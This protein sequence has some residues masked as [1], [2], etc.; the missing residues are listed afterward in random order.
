MKVI[1]V[2]DKV[3]Y[4]KN[5]CIEIEFECTLKNNTVHPHGFLYKFVSP[6]MMIY[7]STPYT[8]FK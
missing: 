6:T 2:L 5:K 3:V 4:L 1:E 7:K 8:Y